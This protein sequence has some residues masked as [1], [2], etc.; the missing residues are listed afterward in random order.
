[1]ETWSFFSVFFFLSFWVLFSGNDAIHDLTKSDKMKLRIDL[2]KFN[3]DKGDVQYS[4]FKVGNKSEKYKLTVG[5]FKGSL[6]M[7]KY[8][9]IFICKAYVYETKSKICR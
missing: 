4:T 7:S 1:M 9:T 2:E 8:L 3:G 5:G 6:G